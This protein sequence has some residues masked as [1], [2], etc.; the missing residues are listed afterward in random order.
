MK[1]KI[2]IHKGFAKTA[3]ALLIVCMLASCLA[4]CAGSGQ[5]TSVLSAGSKDLMQ[6]IR[7]ASREK[8]PEVI[9]AGSEKAADFALKLFNAC[10]KDGENTLVSPISV[11]SALGLAQNGAVGQTLSQMEETL[12]FTQDELNKFIQ[13]YMQ[14]LSSGKKYKL[15]L[16][17]SIW[18]R[19]GAFE[20]NPVFLQTNA[21]Y[22][23]ADAYKAAFDEST[24]K[25]IN[26]WVESN[27]DG[28]IP[29]IIDRITDD[30]QLYLIN[31]LAFDAEWEDPFREDQIHERVFTCADG[32]KK[33]VEFMYPETYSDSTDY[34]ATDGAEGIIMYYKDRKYAFVALLPAEGTSPAQLAASLTGKKLLEMLATPQSVSLIAGIPKFELSWDADLATILAGM[35]MQDAF[36]PG[37]EFPRIGND[38]NFYIDSVIH[39]SYISVNEKG[40]RAGAATAVAMNAT[41]PLLE[42][43]VILDR[44]FLYMLIDCESNI[45]FFIG[46]VEDLPD[47]S[48]GN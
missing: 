41:S 4:G 6:E 40:T 7:P 35:G 47:L 44:P 10:R 32:S 46:V 30:T 45:P 5:R 14:S 48:A 38:A 24:A 23:G 26:R 12:G 33:T 37:A 17:N 9:K 31:A 1:T 36:G 3:A 28:M 29:S 2:Q 34:L 25:D 43:T 22:Y 13:S 20:A 19:D 11:L 39:K 21:D 27:T 16:A 15:S 18:L 8:D 42:K